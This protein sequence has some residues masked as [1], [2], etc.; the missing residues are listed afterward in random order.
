MHLAHPGTSV[1]G[2]C[3]RVLV[4]SR[5]DVAWPGPGWRSTARPARGQHPAAIR[6]GSS[7]LLDY[8]VLTVVEDEQTELGHLLC[9]AR[10]AAEALR[11][12]GHRDRDARRTASA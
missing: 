6:F 8:L 4:A 2:L 3:R 11:D 12:A 1:D 5:T 7:H 9:L 10:D